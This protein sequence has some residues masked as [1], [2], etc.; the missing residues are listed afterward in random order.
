MKIRGQENY[1][2][3]AKL[4]AALAEVERLRAAIVKHLQNEACYCVEAYGVKC[5]NCE[6]RE[7]AEAAKGKKEA[8]H[9]T[10]R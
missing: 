7:A 9:A 10:E 4:E 3:R 6:L 1:E 5:A 8:K 2:L